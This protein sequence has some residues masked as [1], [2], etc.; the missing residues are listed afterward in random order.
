VGLIALPRRPILNKGVLLLR[1]R[2]D[3]KER[4]RRIEDARRG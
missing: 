1:E 4:Y 3:G 2:V